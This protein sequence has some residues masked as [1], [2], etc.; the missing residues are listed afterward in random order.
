MKLK[1][2]VRPAILI[3]VATGGNLEKR[4]PLVKEIEIGE[5]LERRQRRKLILLLRVLRGIGGGIGASP[6]LLQLRNKKGQKR[7]PNVFDGRHLQ[8]K[9]VEKKY[10]NFLTSLLENHLV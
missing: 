6:L 2:G 5:P 4:D 3:V 1:G 10:L 7:A 9:S 8:L